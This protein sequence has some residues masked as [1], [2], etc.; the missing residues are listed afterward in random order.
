[1][2]DDYRSDRNDR[3][4]RSGAP[5]TAPTFDKFRE[6]R[7]KL[8]IGR[9]FLGRHDHKDHQVATMSMSASTP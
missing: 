9:F 2:R 4:D 1:M 5:A 7:F 8:F 3:S 6:F